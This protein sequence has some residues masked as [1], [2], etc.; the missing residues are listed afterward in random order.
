M[1]HK[2]LDVWVIALELVKQVYDLT[3][4]LPR[5]EQFALSDQLRRAS[6]SI[7]SNIAEG[8]GRDS[9]KEIVRYLVIARGSVNEIEAQYEIVVKL[10]FCEP[11]PEL[12]RLISTTRKLLC[13]L[14]KKFKSKENSGH[15]SPITTH[16]IKIL[17]ITQPGRP[18]KVF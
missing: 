12:I 14:I 13:G 8:F 17:L 6:V 3:K 18:E 1:N 4:I 2:N 9:N 7:P 10:Q 5:N 11:N 15:R 16:K